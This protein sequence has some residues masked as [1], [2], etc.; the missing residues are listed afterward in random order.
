MNLVAYHV[1]LFGWAAIMAVGNG[2]IEALLRSKDIH[3]DN[4][5]F[6][7]LAL[8]V[9][10]LNIISDSNKSFVKNRLA[11]VLQIVLAGIIFIV[12][13][14]FSEGGN[15][16]IP[17]MLITYFFRESPK[18]RNAGYTIYALILAAFS[19]SG[20]FSY[21]D[22]MLAL[23]MMLYNSDWLFITVLPFMYLYNGQR[24]KNNKFT[25]YFFYVFYPVHL[26][27]IAL[28]SYFI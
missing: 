27:I 10:T 9:L 12:G 26:W 22:P 17:F 11:K 7:T 3:V 28:I 5:I 6:L 23:D 16:V 14:G 25:K 4:N 1:R 20:V 19:I 24:G 8:G 2:L 21:D 13:F 18:K 15:I